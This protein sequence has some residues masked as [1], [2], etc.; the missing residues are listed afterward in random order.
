M[1]P[2]VVVL[3]GP[4]IT[5]EELKDVLLKAGGSYDPGNDLF[6]LIAQEERYIWIHTGKKGRPLSAFVADYLEALEMDAPEVVEQIR[7]KLGG[8]P[9]TYFELEIRR[10][11]GSQQLAVYFVNLCAESWLC[12]VV[13]SSPDYVFSKEEMQ[14][15]LKEGKGFE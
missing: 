13:C 9:R 14:Q 3:I 15:L 6:G 5:R 7:T 10:T 8:E 11:P 4:E 1:N 12:V 2:S